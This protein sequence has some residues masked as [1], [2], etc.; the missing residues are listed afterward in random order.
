[1]S[2]SRGSSLSVR[3]SQGPRAR[4]CPT[5]AAV[6]RLS[7]P[8]C[9][10]SSRPPRQ[11]KSHCTADRP[12]LPRLAQ[13]RPTVWRDV[14]LTP[15]GSQ[16]SGPS[17]LSFPPGNTCSSVLPGRGVRIQAT[18]VYNC[19]KDEL[20][21][22]NSCLRLPV[23]SRH[24]EPGG[25]VSAK[26]SPGEPWEDRGV[27]WGAPWAGDSAPHP[28]PG[29]FHPGSQVSAEGRHADPGGEGTSCYCI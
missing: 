10:L 19:N 21:L 17:C 25:R 24:P 15:T 6:L 1:M 9:A 5:D 8:H 22:F 29:G 3:T 18:T 4:S 27:G 20:P 23:C 11:M 2:C 7:Q 13:L 12:R 28:K 14:V 26:A 16:A